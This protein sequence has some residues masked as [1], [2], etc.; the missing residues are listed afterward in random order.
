MHNIRRKVEDGRAYLEK[1]ERSLVPTNKLPQQDS[2]ETDENGVTVEQQ[3]REALQA[4]LQKLKE[5]TG[6]KDEEDIIEKLK[7]QRMTKERLLNLKQSIENEKKKLELKKEQLEA[8]LEAVKFSEVK[9]K[10]Q[11]EEEYERNERALK[12]ALEEMEE[13]RKKYTKEKLQLGDLKE[14][15]KELCVSLQPVNEEKLP[16]SDDDVF[17]DE[18]DNT[19]LDDLIKVTKSKFNQMIQTME[20]LEL[21]F[22]IEEPL[23][24][25]YL[26]T[27]LMEEVVEGRKSEDKEGEKTAEDLPDVPSREHIKR[28]SQVMAEAQGKRKGYPK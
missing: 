2:G 22:A 5:V 3:M 11:N 10:E 15:V 14:Q 13:A 6:A 7:S 12:E 9:E 21:Q 4:K 16:D 27:G 24:S 1:V 26:D 19:Y 23:S 25:L 18:E 8:E 28:H 20:E 17:L